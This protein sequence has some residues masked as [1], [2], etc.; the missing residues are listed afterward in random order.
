M[1]AGE[2]PEEPRSSP[3]GPGGGPKVA[4]AGIQRSG[5][6]ELGLDRS[7]WVAGSRQLPPHRPL[8]ILTP[9]RA[10]LSAFKTQSPGQGSCPS[11]KE[12]L[13]TQVLNQAAGLSSPLPTPAWRLTDLLGIPVSDTKR[14]ASNV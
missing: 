2:S 4:C 5:C 1:W 8:N 14:V 13:V 7:G 10:S 9:Q 12:K 3:S 6:P 11:V